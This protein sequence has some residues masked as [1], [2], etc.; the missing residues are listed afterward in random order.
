[1]SVARLLAAGIRAVA[2]LMRLLGVRRALAW[3][4]EHSMAMME[5]IRRAS[6]IYEVG[7]L[8][9]EVAKA[10]SSG[11]VRS[12]RAAS[13]STV[14]LVARASSRSSHLVIVT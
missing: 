3:A 14:H 13:F 11:Y 5:S 10:T 6:Y 8:T 4:R 7:R 9:D 1:M 12:S 2:A